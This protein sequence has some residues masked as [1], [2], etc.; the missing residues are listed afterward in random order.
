MGVTEKP[1]WAIVSPSPEPASSPCP[2]V[3]DARPLGPA[4]Q[5]TR[6]ALTGGRRHYQ[7]GEDGL[8]CLHRVAHGRLFALHQARVSHQQFGDIVKPGQPAEMACC[9]HPAGCGYGFIGARCLDHLA[10]H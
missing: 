2:V 3:E 4:V 8:P 9:E 1:I 6:A 7:F 10:N 5:G